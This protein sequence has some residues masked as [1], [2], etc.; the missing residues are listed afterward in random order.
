MK[1][2]NKTKVRILFGVILLLG[3]TACDSEKDI[4]PVNGDSLEARVVL[5][6]LKMSQSG[7]TSTTRSTDRIMDIIFGETPTTRAATALTT[8]EEAKINNLSYFE[9]SGTT[10]ASRCVK[11]GYASS[12]TAENIAALA[13]STS[14][15]PHKVYVV[16]NLGDVTGDV[17]AEATG[18]SGTK[19]SDFKALTYS[20]ESDANVGTSGLP[21]IGSTDMVPATMSGSI[22][23]KRLVARINVTCNVS[24][25]TGDSFVC[26]TMQLKNVPKAGKYVSVSSYPDNAVWSNFFNYNVLST[27]SATW[28]MPENRRGTVTNTD[29]A[30]KNSLAPDYS[31]YV[32]M[33]GIYTLAGI[34]KEVTYRIYLGGNAT[35]NFEIIANTV[36]NVSITVKG[37]NEADAR[38]TFGTDLSRDVNGKLETAN[39]YIA[40]LG[41]RYYKFN[42][43]IM[44]NGK[45]TPA[46]SV[47][48]QNAPAIVPVTLAPSN[49]IVVWE[50][51]SKGSVIE[52]GSVTLTNGYVTFKTANNSTNGNALI[53]VTDGTNI[54]WSWHIWKVNYD[55]AS[56]YDTYSTSTPR[57][58]KMM[59]Y[60]L[61]AI[62]IANWNGTAAN[63]GDLGLF[64]QWGRKDPFVGASGWSTTLQSLAYASGYER[65]VVLNTNA[66]VAGYSGANATIQYTIL[67]PTH[68]ISTVTTGLYGEWLN[69]PAYADKR[70][71]LWGNPKQSTDPNT[72]NPLLGSKSIYDPCPPGWRVPAMDA[73]T[74]F[75]TVKVNTKTTTH[76]NVTNPNIDANKGFYFY[77]S[78]VFTGPSAYYPASG[79]L[80]PNTGAPFDVGLDGSS[81]S[82]SAFMAGSGTSSLLLFKIEFL[83]PLDNRGRAWG[84]P[85][86]CSQE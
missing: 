74:N 13:L 3:I 72:P 26:N 71:N 86:R 63:A 41:G 65:N 16:A 62:E 17:I 83:G 53:A 6:T 78:G 42:A 82:S 47:S 44:G 85:I 4:V 68:F 27:N 45:T 19:L 43:T 37:C 10:D 51:G 70:D 30:L 15:D 9:F 49:A 12:V 80:D 84:F 69:S 81:W 24:V 25:P 2:I 32:D 39:S 38:I 34:Q 40:P 23:L 58:V 77:Y 1:R 14:T 48:G 59:K 7:E 55:P 60:N 73:Y 61:G 36:Y 8:L 21:M 64:Y 18:A 52:D 35:N 5:Q 50:T 29:A 31:T 79:A 11:K 28:Y 33:T 56:S 57:S 66:T 22:T 46:S 20:L 75:S 67:N 76:Y 54:L